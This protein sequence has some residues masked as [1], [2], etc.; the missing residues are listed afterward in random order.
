MVKA[1]P[2]TGVIGDI[3]TALHLQLSKLTNY[4]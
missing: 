1:Q 4:R 3:I 2:L